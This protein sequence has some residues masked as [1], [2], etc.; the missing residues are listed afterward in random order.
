MRVSVLQCCM[1][2]C[3]LLCWVTRRG[4]ATEADTERL[5]SACSGM[6]PM[7]QRSL[8]LGLLDV[9]EA[10]G[11]LQLE[12]S[13]LAASASASMPAPM[14][15]MPP[16][17]GLELWADMCCSAAHALAWVSQALRSAGR[18]DIGTH[19]A[20]QPP[21]AV[22]LQSSGAECKCTSWYEGG[23]QHC[24]TGTAQME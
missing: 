2:G 7:G 6:W 22:M 15:R 5:A 9:L 20:L 1:E 17:S 19:R 14:A 3:A 16:G 18:K 23:Q 8:L 24:G 12:P 13:Q 10:A 4:K 11:Q 21:P